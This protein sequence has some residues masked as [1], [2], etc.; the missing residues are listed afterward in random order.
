MRACKRPTHEAVAEGREVPS[1]WLAHEQSAPQHVLGD[2]AQRPPK[3][4]KS[5][6]GLALLEGW[7]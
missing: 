5:W 1:S 4:D 3:P 2:E 6:N 7:G